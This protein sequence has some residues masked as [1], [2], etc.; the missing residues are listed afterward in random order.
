MRHCRPKQKNA[1][2]WWT[3]VVSARCMFFYNISAF[4]FPV[5][6]E[7]VYNYLVDGAIPEGCISNDFLETSQCTFV[8]ILW[9]VYLL[10]LSSIELKSC[11]WKPRLNYFQQVQIHIDYFQ[12]ILAFNVWDR[13]F[14]ARGNMGL[15]DTKPLKIG[16]QTN[17]FGHLCVRLNE[18]LGI[19]VQ[20]RR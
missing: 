20:Y 3:I 5:V 1:L 4:R 15:L 7:A 13:D 10:R 14:V 12:Q 9:K 16:I 11:S 18:S 6:V 8:V 17:G 19:G 2:C